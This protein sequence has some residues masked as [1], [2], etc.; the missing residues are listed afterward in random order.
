MRIPHP[1]YL[2]L[3]GS[4]AF[5]Q[6]ALALVGSAPTT[7][8]GLVGQIVG[9]ADGV[10]V[11]PNWVLTA[12]H[13]ATTGKVFSSGY[14]DAVIDDKF[15][16]PNYQFPGNDLAL[17]HL[18][19][20]IVA[21]SY[22]ALNL[23]YIEDVEPYGT[24]TLA[25]AGGNGDGRYVET[26]LTDN[27]ARVGNYN[28]HWIITD[29]TPSGSAIVQGGDSGS[30]LFLGAYDEDDL[31]LGGI[32]SAICRTNKSCYV[33][34]SAYHDWLDITMLLYTPTDPDE[35]IHQKLNWVGTPSGSSTLPALAVAQVS[36]VPEPASYI[37]LILG[38]AL[39]A[40]PLAEARR[41]H[42]K[43]GSAA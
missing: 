25:N 21:D 14:G 29:S 4:L 31:I 12:G 35:A 3:I 37:L 18:A 33:Q 20:P 13:A 19:T 6:P 5:A 38:I 26:T 39:L 2:M 41:A 9:G 22:A 30:G 32:A 11:A 17:L 8:F 40:C 1:A 42:R 24:V 34:P 10:L 36:A 28:V 43:A 7:G 16:L 27:I 15:V 23:A